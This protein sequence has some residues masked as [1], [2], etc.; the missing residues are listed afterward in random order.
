[1]LGSKSRECSLGVIGSRSNMLHGGIGAHVH[2]D[3]LSHGLPSHGPA[4]V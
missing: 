1:M 4:K 2:G 3:G